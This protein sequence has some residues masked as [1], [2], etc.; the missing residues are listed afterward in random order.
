VEWAVDVLVD[1][2]LMDLLK[3]MEYGLMY[4]CDLGEKYVWGGWLF[5]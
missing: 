5:M 1:S 3:S 4:V 2:L